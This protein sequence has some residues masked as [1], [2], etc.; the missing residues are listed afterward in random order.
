PIGGFEVSR[1][2]VKRAPNA[3]ADAR[4]MILHKLPDV[5]QY[6]PG[7][8][9]MGRRVGSSDDQLLGALLY[10]LDTAEYTVP[11]IELDTG[12]QQNA[13]LESLRGLAGRRALVRTVDQRARPVASRADASGVQDGSS[14]PV[15]G[16]SGMQFLGTLQIRVARRHTP[17]RTRVDGQSAPI[18]V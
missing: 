14:Q 4:A 13:V 5:P 8:V 2:E 1:Y 12:L 17:V 11:V 7:H 3:Q 18:G 16:L 10:P 15:L 9:E 6:D